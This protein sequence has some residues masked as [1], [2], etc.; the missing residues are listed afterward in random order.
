MTL[1]QGSLLCPFAG[2]LLVGYGQSEAVVEVALHPTKANNFYI[3]TN[4]YLYKMYNGGDH[5]EN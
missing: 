2:V 4:D 3:A 5:W 1:R